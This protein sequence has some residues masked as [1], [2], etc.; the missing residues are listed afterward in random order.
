MLPSNGA[1]ARTLRPAGPAVRGPTLAP[2]DSNAALLPNPG[3]ANV[4]AVQNAAYNDVVRGSFYANPSE[5]Q[6]ASAQQA[7]YQQQQGINQR[8]LYELPVR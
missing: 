2:V 3:S 1:G 7:L 5:Q 6:P 4:Q 8:A